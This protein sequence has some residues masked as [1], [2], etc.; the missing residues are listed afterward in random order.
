VV[1]ERPALGTAD[2]RAET[3][4]RRASAH[5]VLRGATTA[6]LITVGGL[7]TVSGFSLRNA[8]MDAA[9]TATRNDLTAGILAHTLPW[10][11]GLLA[12]LGLLGVL[13]G[14][15]LL[16]VRAPQPAIDTLTPVG[17]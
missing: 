11:G 10:L 7:V 4:L 14:A 3:V 2:E 13:V 8:A 9:E 15:G 5:R 1:T 6:A 17:P 12:L 16:L